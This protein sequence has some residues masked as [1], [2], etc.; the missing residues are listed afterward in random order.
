MANRK[1]HPPAKSH[2]SG[3]DFGFGVPPRASAP[4]TK[5]QREHMIE[6]AAYYI[7]EHRHFKGGDPHDDWMQAQ[8][9]IDRQLQSAARLSDIDKGKGHH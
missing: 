4:I 8:M 5:E 2:G 3:K 6:E 9:E 7:A 1:Q